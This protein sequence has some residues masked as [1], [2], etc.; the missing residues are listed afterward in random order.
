M[1]QTVASYVNATAPFFSPLHAQ[2][3]LQRGAGLTALAPT[4]AR[5]KNRQS[6][7]LLW[8]EEEDVRLY[9]LASEGSPDWAAIS[10]QFPTKTTHQLMERWSKV[11]NPSLVKGNWTREEDQKILNWVRIHGT[12]SW[13]KLAETMP[14]RIGKQVRE[15]YRNSLNPD[16]NKND[17]TIDEDNKVIH[18]QRAWGNKWAKIALM[19]PGRTD[20]AVKNRWNST[21]RK[22]VERQKAPKLDERPSA[23]ETPS[24]PIADPFSEFDMY[25]E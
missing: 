4:R 21:L 25:M 11:L 8:T 12:S 2:Q 9:R 16:V 3:F 13:T 5:S 15:R 22:R 14:G 10:A 7:H 17:W 23:I 19:I 6:S 1:N 20:N 18:L 24:S